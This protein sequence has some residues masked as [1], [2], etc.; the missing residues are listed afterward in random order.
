MFWMCWASCLNLAYFLQKNISNSWK[1]SPTFT[2]ISVDVHNIL[3]CCFLVDWHSGV[4]YWLSVRKMRSGLRSE[5]FL[6]GLTLHSSLPQAV[7]TE[8][9]L[10]HGLPLTALPCS[11]SHTTFLCF[12]SEI[13]NCLLLLFDQCIMYFFSNTS[14]KDL[15]KFPNILGLL[16]LETFE[17]FSLLWV[18]SCFRAPLSL[19]FLLIF[20]NA[21]SNSFQRKSSGGE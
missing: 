21:L 17:P 3:S 20:L 10:M 8:H 11:C 9:S 19:P 13:K 1:I 5:L 12:F 4:S 6:P 18:S 15:K 2:S 7:S 14:A 16:F